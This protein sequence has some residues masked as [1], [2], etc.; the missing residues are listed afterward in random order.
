MVLLSIILSIFKLE[1]TSLVKETKRI[2]FTLKKGIPHAV[3]LSQQ[4]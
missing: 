4:Y 3:F 2:I 1:L